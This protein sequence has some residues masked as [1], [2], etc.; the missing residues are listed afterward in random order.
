MIMPEVFVKGAEYEGKLLEEDA[1]FC[2]ENQIKIAYTREKIYSS[3]KI[4]ESRRRQ[5]L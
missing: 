5:R 3:T 4:Y 2:E 1:K